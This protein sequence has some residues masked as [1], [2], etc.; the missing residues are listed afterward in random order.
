MPRWLQNGSQNRSQ[1]GSKTPP[2]NHRKNDADLQ[3]GGACGPGSARL[4]GRKAHF[5]RNSDVSLLRVADAFHKFV[6]ELFAKWFC[7][8]RS[9]KS[10]KAREKQVKSRAKIGTEQLSG[11]SL[12]TD[13]C[14]NSALLVN[15]QQHEAK[16]MHQNCQAVTCQ[17]SLLNPRKTL[18]DT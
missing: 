12:S 7:H 8:Q 18:Q 15:Q 11:S 1:N 4:W 5:F 10:V 16:I 17:P 14:S 13:S 6:I 3:P 9:V 2:K